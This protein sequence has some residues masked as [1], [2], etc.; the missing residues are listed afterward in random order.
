VLAVLLLP[1]PNVQLYVFAPLLVFV[2]TKL[3]PRIHCVLLFKPNAAIGCAFTVSERLKVSRQPFE[4]MAISR[5][6]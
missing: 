3:F 2:V 1:S 6:V 4:C 5:I